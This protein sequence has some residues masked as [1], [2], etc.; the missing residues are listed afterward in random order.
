MTS[1][2]SARAIHQAEGLANATAELIRYSRE[3]SAMP[4]YPFG[5]D[6]I[7]GTLVEALHF[8]L[9]TEL[10]ALIKAARP[11]DAEEIAGGNQLLGALVKW[12]SD[13]GLEVPE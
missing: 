13:N 8:T 7:T 1:P 10:A 4:H 11:H 2:P 5:L 9:Q 6:D 3:G 12:L